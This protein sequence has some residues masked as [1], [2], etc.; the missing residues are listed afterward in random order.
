MFSEPPPSVA[1]DSNQQW[2]AAAAAANAAQPL[3]DPEPAFQEWLAT[4]AGRQWHARWYG[5]TY[6][7]VRL[8]EVKYLSWLETPKG[9]ARLA[10]RQRGD[11]PEGPAAPVAANAAAAVVVVI[12]IIIIVVVCC[13]YCFSFH[14]LL[15]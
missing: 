2:L 15:R 13:C 4:S 7:R 9:N 12:I 6:P 1:H 11:H 14:L 3:E 5:P 10:D 8:G